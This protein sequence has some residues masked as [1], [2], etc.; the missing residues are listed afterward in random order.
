MWWVY[1]VSLKCFCDVWVLEPF[2]AVELFFD[3]N[4]TLRLWSGIGELT[5]GGVVFYGTSTLLAVSE[6][7]ETAQIS[8]RGASL[9]LSGVPSSV[10]ALALS[11]PYQGRTAK[12]YFG[13]YNNTTSTVG[14]TFVQQDNATKVYFESLVEVF[15]GYMD[16]MKIEES[17]ETTTI[18][19]L[20]E[21][22]LIDLERPRN[23]RFTSEFQKATYPTDKGFDFV[24][25]MQ[26]LVIN[27]GRS[28]S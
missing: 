28:D 1:C 6:I 3:N 10:V 15:V 8:A 2:F 14:T 18:Q 23:S 11:E 19:L 21:N 13:L 27:W 7:E 20:I 17:G 16:Q 12:I 22:K 24:E 9:T 25:S 26:D 4:E 5:H